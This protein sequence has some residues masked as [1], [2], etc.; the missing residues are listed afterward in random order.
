MGS[1]PMADDHI[2]KYLRLQQELLHL[3][4][5]VDSWGQPHLG[6]DMEELYAAAL[7]EIRMGMS[8][9][10]QERLNAILEGRETPLPQESQ[11][12]D[13]RPGDEMDAIPLDTAERERI[14]AKAW[15][16]TAA[17][18]ARVAEYWSDQC[19]RRATGAVMLSARTVP[20][21]C[22][23][24]GDEHLHH[25]AVEV[26]ARP[27]EDGA[28]MRRIV[29]NRGGV[30]SETSATIAADSKRWNGRRDELSIEFWCEG[31][32]SRS[33][34]HLMQHKGETLLWMVAVPAE[35]VI[36]YCSF[37][38][39]EPERCLGIVVLTGAYD[40]AKAALRTTE[41]GANPGGQL[42]AVVASELDTDIPREEF[43]AYWA[44]R[45]RLFT[46]EQAKELF[47]GIKSIREHETEVP[48][49]HERRD[50]PDPEPD[51]NV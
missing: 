23:H 28:G 46:V 17:E 48:D 1:V 16:N 35:R 12:L 2:W 47:E 41:L 27:Q 11:V 42:L 38:G 13:W 44:H 49:S 6:Q 26:L 22:P 50:W 37:A 34:L 15:M 21:V 32:E 29:R 43:E 7:N 4:Q 19:A 8:A 14:R 45:D 33:I 39:G 20:L 9:P 3:R 40:P 25:D 36:T 30:V 51:E 31:C 5:R 18:Y 10:L 24:C